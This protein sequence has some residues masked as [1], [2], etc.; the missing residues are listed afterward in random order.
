MQIVCDEN[1]KA[2]WFSAAVIRQSVGTN[3]SRPQTERFVKI[4]TI[5]WKAHCFNPCVIVNRARFKLCNLRALSG[6]GKVGH[7]RELL[8]SFHRPLQHQRQTQKSLCK[9]PALN[10]SFVFCRRKHFR[11]SMFSWSRKYNRLHH[12]FLGH[13]F[14][15]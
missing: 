10:F 1:G 5:V 7:M 15:L 2:I 4:R 9:H 14:V 13:S 12:I 6:N 3:C 8:A 11:N